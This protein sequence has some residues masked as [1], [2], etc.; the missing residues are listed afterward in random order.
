MVVLILLSSNY[1]NADK[2]NGK[3][4][5]NA[6]VA[7]DALDKEFAEVLKNTIMCIHLLSY[8]WYWSPFLKQNFG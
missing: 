8:L 1:E 6:I 3:M 2:Q 5:T 7:Y 4:T